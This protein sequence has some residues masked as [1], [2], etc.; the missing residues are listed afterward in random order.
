[1]TTPT[2]EPSLADFRRVV[3][4]DS[5]L[6]IVSLARADGTVATSLVNAGV[7]A[8]PISGAEVVGFVVQ[9]AALKVRRLRRDGRATVTVRAKWGWVAAEGT[10]EL[11]GPDDT[12]DGFDPAGVP[13]LLR[14]VFSAAGGSHDDWATYD[15]VMAE[16]RRTAVLLRPTRVY[17]NPNV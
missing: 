4:G 17:G 11:I 3:A 13:Q 14:A 15:R 6:S 16:Q 9:G 8:H 10:T 2:P 1:M 12:L 5:G 7:L